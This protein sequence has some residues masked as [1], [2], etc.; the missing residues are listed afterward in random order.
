MGLG[1]ALALRLTLLSAIS[2]IIHLTYPVFSAAGQD[3]SCAT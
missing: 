3:F 1:L 2:W